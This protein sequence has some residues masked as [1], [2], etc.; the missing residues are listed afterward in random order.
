[1]ISTALRYISSGSALMLM[2]YA[3]VHAQTPTATPTPAAAQ[4]PASAQVRAIPQTPVATQTSAAAHGTDFDCILFAKET[5]EIRSPVE[6][7]IE[8]V[9][10][11]RGDTVKKGQLIVTLESGPE[12]AQLEL[13]R[14]KAKMRGSLKA[15]ESRLEFA[16]KKEERAAEL[17]KQNFVSVGAYDE[18]KT[19]R[20]LAESELREARENTRLA[21]LEM[22]RAE[23]VV[24]Q[25]TIRS[26]F[27]GVV[28]EKYLS[29]G[30]IATTNIK[31][32]ILK[33]SQ[34][35]PLRVE[36]V[37]PAKMF[38]QIKPGIKG[39]V[40]PEA[41]GG[42]FNASVTLIDRVIDAASGTFGVRLELPNPN[43]EIPA[44][45]KCRVKFQK[46]S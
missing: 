7:M 1:M 42:T 8:Q 15:A 19:Q 22:A 11:Q 33:I 14:S 31:S 25:R 37:L 36:V 16:V 10:V 17:S 41:P 29:A 39:V 5:V 44:G 38:G 12:R 24:R 4:A 45:A 46:S 23:E 6:G 35:D 32:P 26:P 20:S 18:A 3:T 28:V 2:C 13:A 43:H 21:E 9:H 34:I 40:V 27:D 30:E